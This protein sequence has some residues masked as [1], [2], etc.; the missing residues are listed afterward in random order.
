MIADGFDERVAAAM[1]RWPEYEETD[2][3]ATIAMALDDAKIGCT[4]RQQP[5]KNEPSA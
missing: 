1:A 4:M 2:Q 5:S 3:I